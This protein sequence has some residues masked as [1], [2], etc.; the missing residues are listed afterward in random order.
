MVIAVDRMKEITAPTL[1]EEM[2][3]IIRQKHLITQ[4][5]PEEGDD[6]RVSEERRW[7]ESIGSH[8]LITGGHQT[9][10]PI[11]HTLPKWNRTITRG[12]LL[13]QG[14]TA[15]PMIIIFHVVVLQHVDPT[16]KEAHT[17]IPTLQITS[18][19]PQGIFTTTQL[20][21]GQTR[22]PPP[23]VLSGAI[24]GS[25]HLGIRIT[26]IVTLVTVPEKG[27]MSTQDM[28]WSA[29]MRM[30]DSLI[31]TMENTG[32]LVPRGAQERCM[33]EA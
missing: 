33:G 3:R 10:T 7:W 18:H 31:H 21:G 13:H 19:H 32:P 26:E 9:R 4:G 22:H 27:T 23:V 24:K 12:G 11:S 1:K 28:A 20:T 15:P 25:R 5:N 6:L 30:E 8:D 17:S 14:R 29:G 16:A 2:T